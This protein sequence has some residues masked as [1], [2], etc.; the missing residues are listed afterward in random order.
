[1]PVPVLALRTLKSD[2]V[3]GIPAEI[4]ALSESKDPEWRVN[5]QRGVI[6]FV[7]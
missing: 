6:Q 2:A 5:G 1:M 4:A 7:I 3:L